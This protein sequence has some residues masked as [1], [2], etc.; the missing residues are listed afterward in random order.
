MKEKQTTKKQYEHFNSLA[1]G[2]NEFQTELFHKES[3]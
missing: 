3:I 1:Y 2:Q